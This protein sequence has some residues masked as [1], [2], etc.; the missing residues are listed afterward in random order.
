MSTNL[1]GVMFQFFHWFLKKDA[2]VLSSKSLWKFL[3]SEANRLRNIGI[4]AVWIPPAY[5]A[6]KGR[7]SVGYDV[8]DHFDLGEFN[9]KSTIA[10]KYGTK[11]ELKDA[12]KALHGNDSEKY[13]QVYGDIVLNHKSGGDEED[14]FWQAIRVDNDNRN[15]ERWG[16]C[17][18]CGLIEIKG[19]TK[20]THEPRAGKYSSFKWNVR[21]FDSLDTAFEI[22]QNG[23]VFND[24]GDY[25]YRLLYNEAGYQPPSKS[26]ESWVSLE[27]GN[28]DYLNDTDFDYGRHDVREEMKYWGEWF[29]RDVKLDGFRLDAVKHISA[30]YIREWLGH[31]RAKTNRNLFTVG[32]YISGGTKT[33]HDYI[34][35]VTNYGSFPQD[36]SLFDFPLRFMFK[37]A[38]WQ[39]DSFDLRA[40]NRNTLMVEQPAKAVTFVENHDYEYGREPDSHVREWFKPLAYAFILL[41]DKGYPCLFFS[42]YYGSENNGHHRAQSKGQEYL[43]LLLKLRKQFALGTERYYDEKNVVGWVRMG[44]VPN[45]RGAMAVV[46]NNSYRQVKGIRM[47][48]G[49]FNKRFYHLA[50]IKFTG[51]KFLVVKNRYKL[52]G[53]KAEGLWTDENGRADFVADGGTVAIWIEDG[54]GLR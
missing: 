9:Q 6:A 23:H 35:R 8:H 20:F 19:Y 17:F 3:E 49:R 12:I 11:E 53:D 7:D 41:R 50:T 32:E 14:Y 21:H 30:D 18:E 40:L 47:N 42:D 26:F 44:G 22:R 24:S 48:T 45:A 4:D 37:N 38:S 54:V 10:T 5:K 31:V 34:S 28:Y 51:D 27:K 52:Y 36:I 39:G 16:D 33:L 1:N 46:I 13:L 15:H 2:Q 43:D 25:I 29:A